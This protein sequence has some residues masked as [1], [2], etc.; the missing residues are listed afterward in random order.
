MS[1]LNKVMLIGHLGKDPEI[2]YTQAA[3]PVANFGLATSETWNDRDGNKQE[4]TEWHKVVVFG[5]LADICGKYLA[6]GRQVYIEGKLQTRQ[7]ENKEGQKQYSTEIVAT[8]LVFIGGSSGEYKGGGNASKTQQ[9]APRPA[10]QQ[11]LPGEYEPD[12][13]EHLSGDDDYPF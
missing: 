4:K 10:P 5:K 12:I 2:R 6:K 9:P 11:N 8:N 3:M 13:N 1:G 7:W